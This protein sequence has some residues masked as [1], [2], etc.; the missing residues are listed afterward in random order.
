MI[1]LLL[2]IIYL[3][4]I[5]Y[6][7]LNRFLSQIQ[8]QLQDVSK[9]VNEIMDL[10]ENVRLLEQEKCKLQ[11]ETCRLLG[12]LEAAHKLTQEETN[13]VTAE[14]LQEMEEL[15]YKWEEERKVSKVMILVLGLW[16]L[17]KEN[18]ALKVF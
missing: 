4:C 16:C 1:I 15:K 11:Q 12:D 3:P 5:I 7:S 8:D 2:E 6:E 17:R 13:R 18:K 14:K 10:K 9:K